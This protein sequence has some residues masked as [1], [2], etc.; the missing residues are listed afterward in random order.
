MFIKPRNIIINYINER[1]KKCILTKN[2]NITD[3]I[4]YVLKKGSFVFLEFKHKNV[5]LINN[6]CKSN[7]INHKYVKKEIDIHLYGLLY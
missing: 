1:L 3:L 6:Y 2:K 4:N 5:F 7:N